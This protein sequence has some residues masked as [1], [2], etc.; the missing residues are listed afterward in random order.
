MIEEWALSSLLLKKEN[1]LEEKFNGVEPD[2][3]W[4]SLNEFFKT[5]DYLNLIEPYFNMFGDFIV[6]KIS[7]LTFESLQKCLNDFYFLNDKIK[8]FECLGW[9]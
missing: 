5:I 8:K 2:T 4:K 3:L 1:Y 9:T 7:S 6:S